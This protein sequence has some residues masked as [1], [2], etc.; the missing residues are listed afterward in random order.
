MQP[1]RDNIIVNR[2]KAERKTESGLILQSNAGEPD[3]A[4]IVS[5]GPEVEEVTTGFI[6][7]KDK[8][9]DKEVFKREQLHEIWQGFLPRVIKLESAYD[10][11][12]WP[13]RPSGLCKGW[14]HVR[15]CPH[16]KEKA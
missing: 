6:W 4:E 11:D 5:I 7:L 3:R 14:C 2:I 1:T 13:A 8:K 10:R 15:E 16:W 9:V 12:S